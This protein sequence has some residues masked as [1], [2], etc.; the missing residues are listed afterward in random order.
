MTLVKDLTMVE[1]EALPQ[2]QRDSVYALFDS[3]RLGTV[4][5]T[6]PLL[7]LTPE[8]LATEVTMPRVMENAWHAVQASLKTGVSYAAG[9]GDTEDDPSFAVLVV[10]GEVADKLRPT[11]DA[12]R[13]LARGL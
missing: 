4:E 1:L 12:I 6:T 9:W 8:A 7:D 3:I 11:L 13:D 5:Q 2:K 10:T